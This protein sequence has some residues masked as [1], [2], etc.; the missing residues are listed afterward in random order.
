MSPKHLLYEERAEVSQG[1]KERGPQREIP[2]LTRPALNTR[3]TQR[4]GRSQALKPARRDGHPTQA[5][6]KPSRP[7]CAVPSTPSPV[8]PNDI[9][10]QPSTAKFPDL[11]GAHLQPLSVRLN[12]PPA[13]QSRNLRAARPKGTGS[14]RAARAGRGFQPTGARLWLGRDARGHFVFASCPRSPNFPEPCGVSGPS[15]S[16]LP[17]PLCASLHLSLPYLLTN[18]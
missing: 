12:L 15:L 9:E 18:L 10:T 13:R 6:E 11:P 8:T 2:L 1:K 3:A 5:A 16:V 17:H 14:Q 4:G 7:P